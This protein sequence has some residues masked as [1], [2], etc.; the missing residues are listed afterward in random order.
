[1][2]FGWQLR[3]PTYCPEKPIRQTSSLI[4]VPLC[5]PI[6][7]LYFQEAKNQRH[8]IQRNQLIYVRSATSLTSDISA[9]LAPTSLETPNKPLPTLIHSS[10]Q[11]TNTSSNTQLN[12]APTTTKQWVVSGQNGFDSVNLVEKADVPKLGDHDVLV[13][14]HYASLNYRD[15]II[16]KVRSLSLPSRPVISCIKTY[17]PE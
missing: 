7:F 13:N 16:P 3:H 9:Q 10:A 4:S 11:F 12:M 2:R 17:C 8:G 1:M 6:L 5:L 15:L 14:I